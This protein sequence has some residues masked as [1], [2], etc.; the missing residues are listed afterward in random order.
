MVT[1]ILKFHSNS[2]QPCKVLSKFLQNSNYNHLIKSIDVEKD[3]ENRVKYAI[4]RVPTMVY[5][6]DEEK[7]IGRTIG[8]LKTI[9]FEKF[10]NNLNDVDV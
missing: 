5:L 2:C 7:E 1:K 3:Q 6:N 9:E 4:K 8:I 10:V